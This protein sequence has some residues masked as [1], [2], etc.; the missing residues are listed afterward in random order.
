MKSKNLTYTGIV[1][2]ILGIALLF[3]QATAINVV[4]MVVGGAFLLSALIDLIVVLRSKATLEANGERKSTS[5]ISIIST[6]TA[7]ATGALGLWMLLNPGSFS[8]LLVYVFAAIILLA[9]LYHI[10]MLGFGFR[11]ARFPFAFY[12]LPILLVGA[13][14]VVFVLGPVKMMN[15]IVLVTGIALIVYSVCNFLEAAGESNYMK[16]ENK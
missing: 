4:V 6:L 11:N 14:V 1:T 13:G 15:A 7:V 8:A 10:S 5:S 12:I 3:M 9:G 16:I 2:L